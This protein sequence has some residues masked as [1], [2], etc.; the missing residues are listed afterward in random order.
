MKARSFPI[1]TSQLHC[2]AWMRQGREWTQTLRTPTVFELEYLRMD[3]KTI[4]GMILP[5]L[6]WKVTRGPFRESFGAK[7]HA[8]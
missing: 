7:L 3:D 2:Q 4:D 1:G 6:S 8:A 5:P